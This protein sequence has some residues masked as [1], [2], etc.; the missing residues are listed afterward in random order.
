MPES[1]LFFVTTIVA[2]HLIVSEII[3]SFGAIYKLSRGN[4]TSFE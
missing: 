2:E 1:S 4:L 3:F